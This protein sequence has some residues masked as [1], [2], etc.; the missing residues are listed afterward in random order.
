MFVL[1]K[2]CCCMHACGDEKDSRGRQIHLADASAVV[3]QLAYLTLRSF[4]FGGLG[5]AISL[6]HG[7]ICCLVYSSLFSFFYFALKKAVN[8][9]YPLYHYTATSFSTFLFSFAGIMDN[10]IYTLLFTCQGDGIYRCLLDAAKAGL[11]GLSKSILRYGKFAAVPERGFLFAE[12]QRCLQNTGRKRFP[13][14]GS[15]WALS[16]LLGNATGSLLSEKRMIM[17]FTELVPMYISLLK[18]ANPRIRLTTR[19]HL[20]QVQ[21]RREAQFIFHCWNRT[22]SYLMHGELIYVDHSSTR[23]CLNLDTWP[24]RSIK[25]VWK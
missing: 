18:C 22:R 9:L 13:I 11:V 23:K 1:D 8:V 5:Q 7:L 4:D 12:K 16:R 20:R 10:A 2:T 17:T 3:I 15:S 24:A 19:C 14:L 25:R 21:A 6:D